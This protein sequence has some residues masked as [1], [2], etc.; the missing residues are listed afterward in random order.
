MK[1]MTALLLAAVLLLGLAACGGS[2]EEPA[3]PTANASGEITYK[4]S[5]ADASGNPYTSGVIVRFLKDGE[6]AAMQ[7]VDAS[8]A[9][10][11]ALP[12][13]EYTVELM[14]TGDESEYHYEKENLTL[15]AEAPERMVT[16]NYT[17]HAEPVA[18]SAQGK[19][20]QAYPVSDGSTYVTLVPG[21]RNYFLYTPTQAGTFAFSSD[22]ETAVIGYYGA[23]HFVQEATAAE[24]VNNTFT[25]SIRATMI[26]E[27]GGAV[28]VIGIDADASTDSCVL[29][30]QRT[31]D[32][33]WSVEDEPWQVYEPTVELKKYTLGAGSLQEFD[34]TA[35][36]DTYNLVLGGDGY[37]HLDSENG[38]LVLVRLT[39]DPKYLPCFKNILD[40]SG[41][42]RYFYDA[43]GEFSHKETYDQCLL[44]Y[45]ECADEAS[46]TY[47]LTEDL[48][49]IIQQRGEYVGWWDLSGNSYLF[50]D[51]NQV[52]LDGIN[53]EIA[54][55]FMCCYI[56]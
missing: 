4:V 45:I 13:G 37:Y 38:P 53:S 17:M 22:T 47:P 8:G 28:I 24:V 49:Y 9:A 29:T 48:K 10:S 20:T 19:E 41:V 18:L 52:P 46:G 33:A 50:V 56:A 34:L 32:P 31:G 51:E 1:K 14:F 26:G 11:K 3:A 43:N 39:Q 42:N 44:A 2:A 16:L 54:W 12:A 30:V 40:R 7:P 15:T 36:A 23:P 21:E 25:Q 5:V 27:N 55:L 6:Q 35:S